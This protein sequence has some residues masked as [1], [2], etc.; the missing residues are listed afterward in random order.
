MKHRFLLGAVL[1]FGAATV[2]SAQAPCSVE[3]IRGTYAWEMTGRTFDGGLSAATLPGGVPMLEGTV[4]P[5]HMTGVMTVGHGGS[6]EGSYAGLFGLVPL[7][8]PTPL[9]LVASFTVHSDCTGE[10]TAPN[11]FG[12]T[13]TDKFVIIDN[14][15]EI[16]SVTMS[17][18]PF[19]WQF[20]MV[21]IGRAGEPAATCGRNTVRGRYVMRCQGFE[22]APTNPPTYTGVLPLFV[23]DVAADGT[24]A[25]RQFSRDHSLAGVAVSGALMVN[26]DC[27]SLM[28]VQTEAL[29][30]A[31]ILATGVYYDN[32][33]EGFGGPIL[34]LFGGQPA[35]GA[36]AGFAC[37]TTRLTR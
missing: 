15:Q 12:G 11:G 19:A 13:N 8:Y 23:F 17:G 20:T 4:F 1:L 27:T 6:A 36:F 22:G 30:G 3:T 9:P 34:A 7:G 32:G 24:M 21:R 10:M 31:T 37:H 2:A 5:V 28:T 35:P 26:P 33:K 16:R 18:A 25:G 29:P 14:G